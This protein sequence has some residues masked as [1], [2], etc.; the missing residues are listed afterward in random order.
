MRNSFGAGVVLA[1][2]QVGVGS[3]LGVLDW[4]LSFSVMRGWGQLLTWVGF[5]FAVGVAG[6]AVSDGARCVAPARCSASGAAWRPPVPPR[7]AVRLLIGLALLWGER[8][9]P[10]ADLLWGVAAGL[11]GVIGLVALYRGLAIGRMGIVAP[12]SA[13]LTASLPALFGVLTEGMP[14]AS[15]LVGFA[16]ALLGIWL[17]AGTGGLG[18]ARD[19]LGLALLA[20]CGF[21]VFVHPGASRQ[22]RARSSGRLLPRALARWGWCCPSHSADASSCSRIPGC[23]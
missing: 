9:P 3:G 4:P 21:G 18:G 1:A 8:L 13:V 16:L 20:G 2:A 10:V 12:V 22:G 5:I 23:S 7:W 11:A 14:G 17:V 19:G 15:K 6:G